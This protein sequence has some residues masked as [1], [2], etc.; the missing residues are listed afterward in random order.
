VL[1]GEKLGDGALISE[2]FQTANR[3]KYVRGS[4]IFSRESLPSLKL[5]HLVSGIVH[6]LDEE[7][8]IVG[9]YYPGSICGVK[10]LMTNGNVV[11]TFSLHASTD[12]EML[13]FNIACSHDMF[14]DILRKDPESAARFYRVIAFSVF[15]KFKPESQRHL[16]DAETQDVSSVLAKHPKSPVGRMR[17]GSFKSVSTWNSRDGFR[18]NLGKSFRLTSSSAR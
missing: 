15:R 13:E 9:K 12:V 17:K 18:Q 8:D 4:M 5:Y 11:H 10:L 1:P 2:L 3:I 16:A 6:E 14:H 7:G